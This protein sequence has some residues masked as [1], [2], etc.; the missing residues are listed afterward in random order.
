MSKRADRR[1]RRERSR[2][3]RMAIYI[4]FVAVG[5]LFVMAMI[6]Y[7]KVA[8]VGEITPVTPFPFTR[9]DGRTAGDPNAPVTVEV[10]E[11]FQ[12]PA[13][14]AFSATTERQIFADYVETGKAFF[15]YRHFPFLETATGGESSQ[16]A[17]ASMCAA[18]QGR[19]WDYHDMLFA[20][21]NG[22]NRGAFSSRRLEAFAENIGL[23]IDADEQKGMDLGV[24]A[25]PSIVVN[26]VLVQEA[27]PRL[28]PSFELI[29]AAIETA[30]QPATS[31]P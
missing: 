1:Q 23:E 16:A 12:C 11:D 22:E 13:C 29:A 10:Y 24:H 31:T 27:D 20:N 30:L 4:G 25:T 15:I 28:V 26:G 7:P 21:Q 3:R 14:A 18:E 2:H 17:N 19:F 9:T 8:P 6:L 5:A